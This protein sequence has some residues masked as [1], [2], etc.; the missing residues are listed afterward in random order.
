[1]GWADRQ[2]SQRQTGRWPSLLLLTLEFPGRCWES[3]L[4]SAARKQEHPR[5]SVAD[6]AFSSALLPGGE[7]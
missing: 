4:S 5:T 6:T 3:G 1:M 2:S 7:D